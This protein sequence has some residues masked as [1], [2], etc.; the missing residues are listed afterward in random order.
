MIDEN[1]I[2]TSGCLMKYTFEG[3]KEYEGV[4]FVDS[5]DL[6]VLCALVNKTS[7]DS[8]YTNSRKQEVIFA[9]QMASYVL[10]E[11]YGWFLKDIASHWELGMG[12]DTALNAIN[13]AKNYSASDAS[14]RSKLDF[15]YRNCRLNEKLLTKT[16]N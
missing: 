3:E 4:E 6:F 8:L 14:Y 12:H 7:L 2:L 13:K 15:V 16:C 5:E 11:K 9:R 10:K 1:D